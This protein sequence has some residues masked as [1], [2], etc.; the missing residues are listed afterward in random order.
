MN[1]RTGGSAGTIVDPSRATYP[2]FWSVRLGE[3]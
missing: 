3:S 1:G 2:R